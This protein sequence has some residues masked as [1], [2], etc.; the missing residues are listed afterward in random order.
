MRHGPLLFPE[1][2]FANIDQSDFSGLKLVKLQQHISKINVDTVKMVIV[3]MR[4]NKEH[5]KLH[6]IW[7]SDEFNTHE[8][9]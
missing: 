3:G 9:V 1:C 8:G 7:V 2:S 5:F 4:E 6:W